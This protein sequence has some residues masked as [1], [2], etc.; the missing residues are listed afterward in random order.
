MFSGI[1]E[2]M[3]QVKVL[4]ARSQG[5]DLCI[6][7]SGLKRRLHLG[8]SVSVNGCC[9]TVTRLGKGSF[10]AFASHETLGKTNLRFLRLGDRVNL[11]PSMT[12]QSTLDGHMVQGHVEM[13]APLVAKKYRGESLEIKIALPKTL[14]TLVIE[15]G[16]IAVD[17]VSLTI[18]A[19]RDV[20]N[21]VE[22]AINLIPYTQQA[23]TLPEKKVGEF[24][25][26]E[27]DG[28]GRYVAR[29]LKIQRKSRKK[30]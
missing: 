17:G 7:F 6:H 18:N 27:T 10:W 25:N 1:I 15:K 28:V 14:A 4:K 16:S 3:G 29:F 11:E 5:L 21:S 19:V 9:L 30:T 23:T 22:V 2:K 8:D 20:K 26:I 24:L 13:M 12:L